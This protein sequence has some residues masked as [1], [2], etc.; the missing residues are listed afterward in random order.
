MSDY[1]PEQL[2]Q[3]EVMYRRVE[4][5]DGADVDIERATAP[6]IELAA[7]RSQAE[8][9]V[10]VAESA[11]LATA[12]NLNEYRTRKETVTTSDEEVQ[13]SQD[14][15]AIRAQVDRLTA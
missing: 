15:K 6:V 5:L 8:Q 12:T 3:P 1:N 13:Q 2:Q 4:I 14:L 9:T 11:Q 7:Y 10:P